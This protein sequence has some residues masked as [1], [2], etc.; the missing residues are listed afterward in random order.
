[1]RFFSQYISLFTSLRPQSVVLTPNQRLG[2]FVVTQYGLWQ[3]QN[4]N[5]VWQ[6]LTCQALPVWL[7]QQWQLLQSAGHGPAQR[8]ILTSEQQRQLWQQVIAANKNGHELL[9]EDTLSTLAGDAWSRLCLWRKSLVDLPDDDE[10][11]QLFRQWA[12]AFNSICQ[13]REVVPPH[14]VW[15][16]V[17]AALAAGSDLELPEECV[18][19]GFDELSPVELQLI[20]ALKQCGVNIRFTD[21]ALASEAARIGFADA[22]AELR[23]AACWAAALLQQNADVSIGIVV[24]KLPQQRATV[25]RVLLEVF[26]PQAVLP[27]KARHAPP[28]NISAAQPLSQT[29][30]IASAL[31]LL[32]LNRRHLERDLVA[33]I[34]HSPFIGGHAEFEQRV[35]LD[36]RL[37][38][39]YVRVT[40]G[41]LRSEAA[42]TTS[43]GVPLCPIFHQQLRDLLRLQ[44]SGAQKRQK[45]SVWAQIFNDQL[46]SFGW[47]G[48][49]ALDTYEYQ[50]LGHWNELLAQLATFDT[51]TGSVSLSDALKSLTRLAQQPFQAQT[52]S[53]PLQVLGLLEAAGQQF[54]YLWIMGLDDRLW[55]E[56]CQPNPLLPLSLQRMWGMP[57]ASWERELEI[58]EKLTARLLHS[59]ATVRV[60]YPLT[61]GDQTLRPSPLIA[62]LPLLDEGQLEQYR[63]ISYCQ[64]TAE[65]PLQGFADDRAPPLPELGR[66]VRGGTAILKDQAACPF[67]AF[68]RHRLQ[69]RNP[70]QAVAGINPSMRGMLLHKALELIWGRLKRQEKLLQSTESQLRVL[71]GGCLEEAWSG[72]SL[73][74]EIGIRQQQMEL[75]RA[76]RLL[77]QWLELEKA[78]PAFEVLYQEVRQELD[79]GPLRLS[80]R[81]DRVDRLESGEG[82]L[83]FDYKT[84]QADIKSWVGLRLDEPQVPLY[85]VAMLAQVKAAAFGQISIHEVAVKGIAEDESV[86]PCL[87]TPAQLK[88]LDLP[89]S[90]PDLLRH[91]QTALAELAEGFA[92]GNASVDPKTRYATCRFCDLHALCR[93]SDHD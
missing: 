27:D 61:E 17:A 84:G 78:R 47:P 12:Q 11:G 24:P 51:I 79:I 42:K 2:R 30:L 13:E 77:M 92:Q 22:A 88:R 60:S 28:F 72:L 40:V 15:P 9:Q 63:P 31:D 39:Y 38:Q 43:K 93:V 48:E 5:S 20:D 71:V 91:W 29:P 86:W 76:Q 68:A 87:K 10:E 7:Q 18:F 8:H 25:E 46:L 14:D 50:Q 26:E 32:Q 80:V 34:L 89:G 16:V 4:G 64:A 45:Y 69:A 67:K 3:K 74:D 33:R 41:A 73:T 49:R 58:A 82:L 75:G 6:G 83:V 81:F 37:M 66:S 70:E 65:S 55:P 1:M 35:Q 62:A 21:I 85:A 52:G 54:D 56:P 90:W 53:S 57:R 36:A 44:R 59:A 19:L 23:A